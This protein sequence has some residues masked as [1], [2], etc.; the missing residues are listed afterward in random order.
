MYIKIDVW[1][2]GL[3]STQD[4]PVASSDEHGCNI[5]AV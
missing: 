2:F 3:D 4:T 5:K 1:E